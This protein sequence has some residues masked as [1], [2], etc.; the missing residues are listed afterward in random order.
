MSRKKPR[1]ISLCTPSGIWSR[2]FASAMIHNHQPVFLWVYS[3]EL[4]LLCWFVVERLGMMTSYDGHVGQ[5]TKQIKTDEKTAQI[6]R[7][8]AVP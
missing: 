1:K 7:N 2:G 5:T 3:L 6:N 8:P 4:L